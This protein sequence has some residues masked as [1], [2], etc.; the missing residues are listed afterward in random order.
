L[1][2]GKNVE[3]SIGFP[4]CTA[5]TLK[6]SDVEYKHKAKYKDSTLKASFPFKINIIFVINRP[7][8]AENSM[9]LEEKNSIKISSTYSLEDSGSK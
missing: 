5:L 1:H 6:I 9:I 8:Y 2:T 7:T 4:E 3:I